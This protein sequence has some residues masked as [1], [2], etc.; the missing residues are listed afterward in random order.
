MSHSVLKQASRFKDVRF[1]QDA[2]NAPTPAHGG[3]FI[4]RARRRRLDLKTL[5]GTAREHSRVYRELAESKISL[6]EAETKSRVLRR[7]SEILTALETRDQVDS[8]SRQLEALQHRSAPTNDP[9]LVYTPA[10]QSTDGFEAS[11]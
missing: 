1:G 10:E 5:H 2:E 6:I 4:Q 11:E 3:E 7:H 8:I 9:A